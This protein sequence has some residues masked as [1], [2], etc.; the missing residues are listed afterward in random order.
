MADLAKETPTQT[1]VEPAGLDKVGLKEPFSTAKSLLA[2]GKHAEAI[3]LLEKEYQE[4]KTRLGDDHPDAQAAKYQLGRAHLERGEPIIAIKVFE[5]VLKTM[6]GAFP[7]DPNSMAV[8]VDL[9]RAYRAAGKLDNAL[10]LFEEALKLRQ[11]KLGTDHPDTLLAM[12][13]LGTT[14]RDL[15][16][17][18]HMETLLE[19]AA[20]K[21]T[22]VLGADHPSTLQT[23]LDLADVLMASKKYAAAEAI[24]RPLVERWRKRIE[25]MSNLAQIDRESTDLARGQFLFGDCLLRQG[26]HAEAV[27]SLRECLAIRQKKEPESWTTF[28]TKSMLGGALVGQRKYAD[29]EPLLL[30]G[31]EGLKKHEKTIPL[32]ARSKISETNRRLIELYEAT[33]KKDEAAKCRAELATYEPPT[34][35]APATSSSEAVTQPSGSRFEKSK[36]RPGTRKQSPTQSRGLL[37]GRSEGKVPDFCD[38]R[39]GKSSQAN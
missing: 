9:A 19:E 14:Y 20:K 30:D 33:G 8:H 26:K 34:E 7:E 25:S 21:M 35:K 2:E 31:Y 27:A 32:Q 37:P 5:E 6:R 24:A 28:N 18:D 13:E 3:K 38:V 1:K 29:A 10:P 22:V 4:R 36:D 39:Q 11:A 17:L 16:K 12:C 23:H 15:G